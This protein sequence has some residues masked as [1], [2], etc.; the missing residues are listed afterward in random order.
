[1]QHHGIDN[2]TILST[3]KDY[4]NKTAS[5][6]IPNA[7]ESRPFKFSNG[8]W[9]GGTRTPEEFNMIIEHCLSPVIGKWDILDIGFK[10]DGKEL[11]HFV[12]ADNIFLLSTNTTEAQLMINDVTEALYTTGYTWKTEDASYIPA[13][14]LQGTTTP[15]LLN[16]NDTFYPIHPTPNSF[17]ILGSSFNDSGDTNTTADHRTSKAERLFW[18]M[19][20]SLRSENATN[21]AKLTAWNTHI[22]PCA[23]HGSPSWCIND[24]L[25]HKLRTWELSLLRKIINTQTQP[26]YHEYLTN[27]AQV[28]DRTRSKHIIPHTIHV[29]LDG[30]FRDLHRTLRDTDRHGRNPTREARNY[31]NRRWWNTV[32]DQSNY[33][34]RKADDL[35]LKRQGPYTDHEDF[36]HGLRGE[37]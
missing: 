15:L 7:G 29:L 11:N 36:I 25:L 37:E 24:A 1:M 21:L 18:S 4:N 34:K 5:I 28:I 32:K 13:G 16:H 17:N 33:R 9:Q 31:R 14:D 27:S 30:Y 8:G 10:L 19:Y 22:I 26:T 12:W 23:L 6:I 2:P 35:T 20:P 3:M